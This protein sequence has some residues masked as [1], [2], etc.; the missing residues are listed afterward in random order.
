MSK[1]RPA[2]SRAGTG[3]SPVA[4]EDSP[5]H[6]EQFRRSAARR[7]RGV[8]AARRRRQDR[9][10]PGRRA[11]DRPA[12]RPSC[13]ALGINPPVN[14]HPSTSRAD[15]ARHI[16]RDRTAVAP[17]C[18]CALASTRHCSSKHRFG[19]SMSRSSSG[20]PG[21]AGHIRLSAQ[22]ACLRW[23]RWYDPG[24]LIAPLADLPPSVHI[25]TLTLLALVLAIGLV[26]DDA[27]VMLETSIATSSRDAAAR[28]A[29]TG[30]RE[31]AFAIIP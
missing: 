22:A 28:T 6:A 30:S 18:A 23:C 3:S 20:R 2:G 31:I 19:Q 8:C 26:V 29:R 13:V 14:C 17:M 27:I 12:N 25:N 4:L 11:A 24:P 15:L 9:A 16:A 5:E 10:W 21:G 7:R 1:F